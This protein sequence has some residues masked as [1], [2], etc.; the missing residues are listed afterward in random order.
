MIAYHD[1]SLFEKIT[2]AIQS[3]ETIMN[4]FK[5]KLK[6]EHYPDKNIKNLLEAILLKFKNIR[7][8]WFVN[9]IRGQKQHTTT[10]STRETVS[11]KKEIAQATADTRLEL[12]E[13]KLLSL[14]E[15]A[16]NNIDNV[17][18]VSDDELES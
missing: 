8:R 18:C 3:N 11:V 14:Y 9:K 10:F 5:S 16:E 15:T 12:K 13:K 17:D 2:E 7:G 6:I 4:T 1:G